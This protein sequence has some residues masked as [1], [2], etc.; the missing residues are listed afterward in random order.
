LSNYLAIATVTAA[1]QQILREAITPH[2][3]GAEVSTLRPDELSKSGVQ[4]G[5]NVYLF[6][7]TPN[8]AMRNDS[9][10][11]RDD[12]GAGLN[13]TSLA[14]DL[15]YI[16]SFYGKEDRLE[17]E[18]LF[19]LAALALANEPLLDSE[20]IARTVAGVAG[21]ILEGSD[22]NQAEPVRL[23][24]VSLT[25]EEL[26]RTWALFSPTPYRLSS[27]YTASFVKMSTGASPGR[28]LPV[29]QIRVSGRPV[30]LPRIQ[31]W[32]PKRLPA[33][34]GAQVSISGDFGPDVV[35]F[36]DDLPIVTRA[37]GNSLIAELPSGLLAGIS[38]LRLGYP[39]PEGE[40]SPL[41][42]SVSLTIEPFVGDDFRVSIENGMAVV[43]CPNPGV[44]VSRLLELTLSP[45]GSPG[46][47]F[48]SSEVLRFPLAAN[49]WCEPGKVS[50]ALRRA[51]VQNGHSIPDDAEVIALGRERRIRTPNSGEPE[52]ALRMDSAG[53]FALYGLSAT[54]PEGATPFAF[55]TLP[56]GRYLA[57]VRVDGVESRLRTE[58]GKYSGP[59]VEVG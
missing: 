46:R 18:Q 33:T 7:V 35:A 44:R 45:V 16:L 58:D 32:N 56:T 57:R 49:L 25:V 9:F 39:D 31:D 59:I 42:E 30:S 48:T 2:V 54:D 21:A 24:P 17:P 40:P 37:S 23:N 10:P 55:A 38:S 36:L 6:Q 41:S 27:V 4:S 43:V 22:I 34:P 13:R 11:L 14:F 47:G 53:L 20:R 8:S 29:A 26:H 1:I 3:R 5:I 15:H 12:S 51:F 28:N 50:D 52:F 19:A